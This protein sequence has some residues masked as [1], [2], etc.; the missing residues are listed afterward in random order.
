[1]PLSDCNLLRLIQGVLA[2]NLSVC[3]L[4]DLYRWITFLNVCD[5]L[6]FLHTLVY[7]L[8]AIN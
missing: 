3:L 4:T 5:S 1:M 7:H 8:N 6:H 2:F